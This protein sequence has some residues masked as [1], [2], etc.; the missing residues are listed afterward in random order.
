HWTTLFPVEINGPLWSIG[1]EVTA[2]VLLPLGFGLVALAARR[3]RGDWTRLALWLGVIGLALGAHWLFANL[4]QVDP[5][6]AGFEHGLQGGAKIWMPQI[7]PFSMFA[8]FAI[9]ALAGGLQVRLSQRRNGLFDGLAALALAVTC[10]VI[11]QVLL[12]RSVESYGWLGVPYAYPGLPLAL[13]AFLAV[14]PS[15][16]LVGK[17]LDNGVVRFLAQISFGIYVWHYVVLELVLRLGVP[18]Q[19]SARFVA[20]SLLVIACSIAVATLSFRYLESPVIRWARWLE[21]ERG[22]PPHSAT[23]AIS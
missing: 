7:N 18:G 21:G 22:A 13:G 17:A 4:V 2:Y 6:D 9:G 19:G 20:G 8:I 10:W 15:T 14:T 3:W 23:E 12:G 11:W 1:F 16:M 5:V